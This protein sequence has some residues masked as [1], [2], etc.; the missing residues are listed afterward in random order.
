M[1]AP[2]P[3]ALLRTPP[4]PRSAT[5]TNA[6]RQEWPAQGS[7]LLGLLATRAAR[8]PRRKGSGAAVP[9]RVSSS[10]YSPSR[11]RLRPG[12][13]SAGS[14]P[15]QCMLNLTRASGARAAKSARL[16]TCAMFA[17][18]KARQLRSSS[19]ALY[20]CAR[21]RSEHAISQDSLSH[22]C[23]S[24]QRSSRSTP[25]LCA[26]ASTACSCAMLCSAAPEALLEEAPPEEEEV[27]SDE[28]S[29]R[30]TFC[31][32]SKSPVYRKC[33]SALS[34]GGG[35]SVTVSVRVALS[36]ISCENAAAKTS[37]RWLRMF[38]CAL[39]VT[40]AASP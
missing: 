13:S 16:T 20:T 35:T 39:K 3:M 8:H 9:C 4:S 31:T 32:S 12:S 11:L 23:P 1:S 22:S 37:L 10:V 29:S 15:A 2:C 27:A 19:V 26:A 17:F 5:C 6:S 25:Y 33:S 24:A 28:P 36:R 7:P 14:T 30:S 21:L 18:M 38:V 34:A 40:G